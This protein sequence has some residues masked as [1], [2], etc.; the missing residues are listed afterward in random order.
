MRI[1]RD[2]VP[3]A[4]T[5]KIAVSGFS[6]GGKMANRIAATRSDVAAVATIHST[7][8]KFDEEIM[9]AALNKHPI[10][11]MF[12]LGTKDKVLPLNGGKSF[13]T[14]GLENNHLSRPLRQ[15]EYWGASNG[16][17]L[18]VASETPH[19]IRRDWT[20]TAGNNRVSEYVV[21]G[22]AHAIDGALPKRNLIQFLM[23][24]PKPASVFDARQTSW[25]FMIESLKRNNVLQQPGTL[26]QVG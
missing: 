8:D 4:N 24:V 7:I 9:S 14:L 22:G 16:N 19:L 12:I 5:D 26:A 25:D 3:N 18:S 21:K 23:G 10:D 13:L 11:G 20:S 1:V 17:P 6:L 2:H 15:A